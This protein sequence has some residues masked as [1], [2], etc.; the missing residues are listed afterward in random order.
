MLLQKLHA[1]LIDIIDE[2]K[3]AA[4]A[5]GDLQRQGD[6]PVFTWTLTKRGSR[7]GLRDHDGQPATKI[8]IKHSTTGICWEYA[9][10]GMFTVNRAKS[11]R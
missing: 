7:S 6:D 10:P 8:R 1:E 2:Y 4:D 3:K 11:Y 9:P 5:V